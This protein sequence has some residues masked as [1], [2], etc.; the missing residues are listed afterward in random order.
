MHLANTAFLVVAMLCSCLGAQ[1]P[2][3]AHHRQ[4]SPK[5]AINYEIRF[6]DQFPLLL[7]SEVCG[8]R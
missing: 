6:S 2:T 4:V 8:R 7:A 5:F 1:G 3:E